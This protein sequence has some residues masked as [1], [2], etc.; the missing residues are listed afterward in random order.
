MFYTLGMQSDVLAMRGLT[1]FEDNGDHVV[2]RTPAEPDFWDGNQVIFRDWSGDPERDEAV[3]RAAFPEASHLSIQWDREGVNQEMVESAFGPSFEIFVEQVMAQT[4]PMPPADAPERIVL[5]EVVS[6]RDWDQVTRL[7]TEIGAEEGMEGPLFDAHLAARNENRRR[8]IEDGHG[9]WFGAFD[10][11][12]LVAGMGMF[13]DHRVARY[14]QVETAS[15]HRRMGICQ[16]LLR[17]VR[18]WV[19]EREPLAYPVIV[20]EAD[21]PAGRLYGRMGFSVVERLPVVKKPGE[22]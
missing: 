11:G 5:R 4:E 3:F 8:Q 14:Q 1:V 13:H 10:D 22:T 12:V 15:T 17:H 21:G 18:L 6:D 19:Q 9:G 16:A 2:L 20:A 7:Q